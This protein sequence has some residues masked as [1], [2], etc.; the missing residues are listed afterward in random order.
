[1]SSILI[2]TWDGGGTIPPALG[3]ARQL[4]QRGHQVTILSDPTVKEEARAANCS[5]LPFVDAPART[6]RDPSEM[7][8][9]D[10]ELSPFGM[11]RL[12]RDR[13]VCAPAPAYA[14]DVVHAVESRPV[15]V[16][17]VDGFLI[18]GLIGA[19]AMRKRHAAFWVGPQFVPTPGLPPGGPGF[20]PA[21]GVAGRIRDRAMKAA[22]LRFMRGGLD[23]VNRAR[24]SRGLPPLTHPFQQYDRADRVLLMNSEHF[25]LPCQL[26]ANTRFIGAILE[27]PTWTDA[28]D[29]PVSSRPRVLVSLGSTFQNQHDCY[30]RIIDALSQMDVDAVVTLGNV[31]EPANFTAGEN[32]LVVRSAPHSA[33]LPTADLVV[34]HGGHGTV[35]KT[36]AA[37]VPMVVVPLGRDQFD[38]GV[39]VEMAG[40]GLVAKKSSTPAAFRAVF[41]EVLG[42][43]EIR[44]AARTIGAAI[45]EESAKRLGIEEVEQLVS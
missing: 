18:G 10:W 9:R 45:R 36:L 23:S 31:F 39:R 15:D 44:R 1:M 42:N 29:L 38:D 21:R 33:I 32:V 5:F 7:V 24:A 13:L 4:I 22:F 11:L 37:G 12:I 6:S 35:I 40:V 8:I 26:P 34:A 43:S 27:D 30:Q 28:F 41:G 3:L 14:A 16:V 20:R 25:E 19:E 17:L 2:V